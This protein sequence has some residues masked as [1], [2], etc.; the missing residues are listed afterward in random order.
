MKEP[1]GEGV[2]E[3][4][5]DEM[6]LSE[7]RRILPYPNFGLDKPD[8]GGVEK[9]REAVEE[10]RVSANLSEEEMVKLKQIK[11]RD[12]YHLLRLLRRN[13]ETE[14]S[15]AKAYIKNSAIYFDGMY[16]DDGDEE[17]KKQQRKVYRVINEEVADSTMFWTLAPYIFKTLLQKGVAD[18]QAFSLTLN[19][20]KDGVFQRKDAPNGEEKYSEKLHLAGLKKFNDWDDSTWMLSKDPADI[21]HQ[22]SEH[23]ANEIA[24]SLIN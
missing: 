4:N 24:E 20:A 7:I 21:T 2:A 8:K 3:I 19:W 10:C 5:F 14:I 18:N 12:F 6:P 23:V 17:T 22:F 1:T 9:L 11:A 15:F 16:E 13:S